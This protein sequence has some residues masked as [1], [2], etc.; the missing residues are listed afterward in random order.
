MIRLAVAAALALVPAPMQTS[1]D[2]TANLHIVVN[3][4]AARF[5]TLN[6]SPDAFVL[7]DGGSRT[8][9]N[10]KAGTYVVVMAPPIEG[11]TQ[12]LGCTN[13]EMNQVDLSPGDDVTCTF[14]LT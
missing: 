5:V 1:Q 12:W 8:F 4:S 3:G 13:G 9:R 2:R 6:L 11:K 7:E 14:T 10:L